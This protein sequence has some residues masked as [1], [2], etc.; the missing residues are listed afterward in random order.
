MIERPPCWPE[1]HGCPHSCARRYYRH[2][3]YGHTDLEGDWRGWRIRD[4]YLIAPG[5]FKFPLRALRVFAKERR[6]SGGAMPGRSPD[7]T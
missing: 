6:L 3:V 1:G 7:T 2:H 4:R 5:G